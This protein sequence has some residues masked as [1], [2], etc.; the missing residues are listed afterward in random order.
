MAS[1]C[2]FGG[3]PG[4]AEALG[5]DLEKGIPDDDQH[6]CCRRF[7]RKTSNLQASSKRV[8]FLSLLRSSNN[9]II[10]LLLLSALLS[11]GFG[12]KEEGL[13]TGWCEGVIILNGVVI[14]LVFPLIRDLLKDLLHLPK[15][16]KLMEE[17]ELEVDVVRGGTQKKIFNSEILL[18]DVVCL[19]RGYQIPGDGLFVSGD[20]VEMDDGSK[21][22]VNA[23]NP[24]LFYGSEVINGEGRM[25]VTSVDESTVW[26]EMMSSVCHFN[27][28]PFEAQL[29][30]INN[31][32]QI[33][34]VAISIFIIVVLFLRS[35]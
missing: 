33:V 3:V 28:T 19:K 24:F 1:L 13:R 8:I 17:K 5:T 6:H 21:A 15:K 7:E 35:H 30:K 23:T 10:F 31:W 26:A 32:K 27:R 22:I 4:F 12:I 29:D 20:F 34:G 14:L 9:Y 11:I 2:E 16:Q 25:L 18:G